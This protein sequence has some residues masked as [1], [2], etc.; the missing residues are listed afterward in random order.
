[1][2]VPTQTINFVPPQS[3]QRIQAQVGTTPGQ[4]TTDKVVISGFQFTIDADGNLKMVPSP[5]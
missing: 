1:M 5:L 4:I 2:P 3:F